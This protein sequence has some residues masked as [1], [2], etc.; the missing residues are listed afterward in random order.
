VGPILDASA[1]GTPGNLRS[2]ATAWWMQP[3]NGRDRQLRIA[4]YVA[5]EDVTTGDPPFHNDRLIALLKKLGKIGLEGCERAARLGGGKRR[6]HA[7]DRV[8]T[9]RR[10][11]TGRTI[12]R[13][14]FE[15]IGAM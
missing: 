3:E 15:R 5:S 6:N 14:C 4:P 8:V 2:I 12:N 9:I 10:S 13:P 1:I 11:L 7:L